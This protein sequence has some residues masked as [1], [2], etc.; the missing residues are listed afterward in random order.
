V[1]ALRRDRAQLV[2]GEERDPV[3]DVLGLALRNPL[4]QKLRAARAL[5]GDAPPGELDPFKRGARFWP[6]EVQ[7]FFFRMSRTAKLFRLIA[8]SNASQKSSLS[9]L[10]IVRNATPP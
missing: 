10:A 7:D 4:A 6:A 1:E 2:L 3:P 8:E 5:D 9:A